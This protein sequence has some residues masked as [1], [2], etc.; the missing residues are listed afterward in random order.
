M[1]LSAIHRG[2]EDEETGLSAYHPGMLTKVGGTGYWAASLGAPDF[3]R[4]L[5]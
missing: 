1:D 3:Q 4:R 2:Y 5:L